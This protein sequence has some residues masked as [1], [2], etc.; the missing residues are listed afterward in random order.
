M[1]EC[2]LGR[3]VGADRIDML[4]FGQ[5]WSVHLGAVPRPRKGSHKVERIL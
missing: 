2:R 3:R 1:N 5:N 4:P